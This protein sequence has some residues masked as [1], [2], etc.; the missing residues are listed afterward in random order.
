MAKHQG[1][2][3][4]LTRQMAKKDVPN[5]RAEAVSHLQKSGILRKGTEKLTR[6][7]E[8]RTAMG[9]AGRAIDRAS[10]LS[11]HPPSSYRYIPGRGAILK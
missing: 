7:G 9:P 2:V 6:K 10:K 8:E 5:A 4:R 11:G 3:E 1:M